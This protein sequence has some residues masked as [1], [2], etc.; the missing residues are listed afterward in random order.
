[1]AKELP[2]GISGG[3]VLHTDAHVPDV[4]AVFRMVKE[5]GAFDYIERTPPTGQLEAFQRA[6]ATH[7][8]PLRSGGFFY[9]LGRDEPLLEWHLRIARELGMRVQ[10]VQIPVR[11]AA[12][13]RVT[14]EQVAETYLW[15]AELGDKLGVTPCFEVHIN[16]WSE[17][18][19]RVA[20]VAR[21][22]EARGVRYNMTLD[23]SHVIFKID[24]PREL[25][26]ESL[27]EDLADG[28]VVLDPAKPGN[29]CDQWID[30]NWVA[31]AHARPAV[32]N[33]PENIWA[34][35]PNG[36]FGRGVQ[37]PFLRPAEGEWHAPWNEAALEPWKQ[38]LRRLFAHHAANPASPLGQVTV[39]MIPGI[40]YGAGAKYSIFEHSVAVAQWLRAAWREAQKG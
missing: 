4:D 12:G 16:M 18:F 26:I 25:A 2:I 28:S 13:N 8:V 38:V 3:G 34:R 17:R 27:G 39:E 35:H 20:N 22:V 10:N 24:N 33:N 14:D 23:H 21:M 19:R 5:S 32:P 9:A 30:A 15:A 11:D 6:S 40:D 1:M 31:H 7:G 37:Y 29:V 36:K